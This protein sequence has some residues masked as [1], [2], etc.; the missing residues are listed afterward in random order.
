MC[1]SSKKWMNHKADRLAKTLY[2]SAQYDSRTYVR[3]D[4]SQKGVF[5]MNIEQVSQ[6]HILNQFMVPVSWL[7]LNAVVFGIISGRARFM[8]D[9]FQRRDVQTQEIG[10][11]RRG[12]IRRA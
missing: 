6:Q 1:D 7:L 4:G 9:Q 11:K 12:E 3:W 2:R 10:G 5:G 8:R